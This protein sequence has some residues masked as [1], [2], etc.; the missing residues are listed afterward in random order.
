MIRLER[1][2]VINMH[3]SP[4]QYF[5]LA[6][7]F[8]L[9]F[10][11]VIVI[12]VALIEF[13]IIQYAYEKMGVSRRYVF[14]ILL[15]SLAGSAINIPVAELPEKEVVSDRIVN[16]FGVLHVIPMVKEWP[17]TI[18]AVNLGGAVV[19]L[20]LSVYLI[21]KN[22]LYLRGAVA[23]AAVSVLVHAMSTPVPGLGIAVPPLLPGVF[24]AIIAVLLSRRYSA[25][26]AYISGSMGTLI[27]ADLLNLAKIQ[28]LGAP[29]ASLGGAGTYD[30]IFISGIIAVLLA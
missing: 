3:F 27:G 18:I 13:G 15:L 30:G 19:P 4:L 2:E 16:F 29:I 23:I 9:L 8:I 6:P 25:P 26:L 28:G 21:V 12:I 1:N 7:L 11:F 20:M 17:H 10:L 5:P 22:G 24:S 14:A